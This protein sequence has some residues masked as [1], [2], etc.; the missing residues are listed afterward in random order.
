MIKN[1]KFIGK[2][3]NNRVFFSRKSDYIIDDPINNESKT[4]P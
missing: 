4:T 1:P 3:V 2:L